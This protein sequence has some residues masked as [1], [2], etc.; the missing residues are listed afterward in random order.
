MPPD[1]PADDS[2]SMPGELIPVGLIDLHSSMNPQARHIARVA[3]ALSEPARV[4]LLRELA[5]RGSMLCS[6]VQQFLGLAQP[7]VSHHI[8]VLLDAGLLCSQREGRYLRIWLNGEGIQQF[9]R[10]LSEFVPMTS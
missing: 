6:E 9:C 1:S 10:A 8:K 3:R 7:T 4:R 5:R 2:G